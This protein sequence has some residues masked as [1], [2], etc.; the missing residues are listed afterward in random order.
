[1]SEL[2]GTSAAD[3]LPHPQPAAASES[4]EVPAGS[5]AGDHAV[6]AGADAVT[7]GTAGP[8]AADD[9]IGPA[10]AVTGDA[11]GLADAVTGDAVTGDAAG[12]AAV[13]EATRPAAADPAASGDAAPTTAADPEAAPD[14][15]TRPPDGTA[16]EGTPDLDPPAALAPEPDPPP[17]PWVVSFGFNLGKIPD[18]GEDSNPILGDTRGEVGI[19]A[20]FDGMGGAGGTVYQ[21]PDG[22]RSGAYLAARVARTVVEQRIVELVAVGPDL[23]RPAAALDLHDRVEDAL[24]AR[25]ADLQAPPSALRSKLLRALPTTMALAVVQRHQSDETSWTCHLMW[26]GDSRIYALDPAGGARQLTLDDVRDGGDAMANLREDSVVSN[27]M[28]ADVP[29][30]VH[31][32][33]VELTAPFLLIAASDGCFGYFPSPMHFEHLILATLSKAPD[34][35]SWSAMVQSRIA[36]VTGDDASMALLGAG[37][38]H[39]GLRTL[40]TERLLAFEKRWVNPLDEL[41]AEVAEAEEKLQRLRDRHR[42]QLADLWAAYRPDYLRYLDG[43]RE[44]SS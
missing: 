22:P 21:T 23:D 43:S 6:G 37:A 18:H 3:Q 29:F 24:A 19:V 40:F 42:E 30:E 33:A 1:V 34:T 39:D 36:A 27:A 41:A 20:V 15:A 17:P 13:D 10:D 11:I 35:R 25:F 9:A 8:A 14:P 26:A 38:D 2:A 16:A 4:P 44:E 31:H 32:G 5:A 7:D 12:T 28:S